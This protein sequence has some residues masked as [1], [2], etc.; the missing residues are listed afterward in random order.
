MNPI[1]KAAAI[2][3]R[4]GGQ[5][6]RGDVK[7]RTAEALRKA[8]YARWG[9]PR[10]RFWSYVKKGEPNECWPWKPTC[11]VRDGYGM[12]W[13]EKRNHQA[14]RL[15]YLFAKG[16]FDRSKDILHTCDNPP[17]CNPNH[18]FVGTDRDN[19]QDCLRKNRRVIAHGEMLPQS[20]L[21]PA[22]VKEIRETAKNGRRVNG[23]LARKFG[24]SKASI[25]AI[26]HRH[27]WKR[28]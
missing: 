3:G 21:S 1:S 19:Q 6:G 25:W 17:C 27:N 23:Q 11:R 14:H 7:A 8:A 10:E 5:A 16:E 13:F 28:V 15:A 4:K 18:L 9:N 12:F 26:V 24:V 22:Q 20:K 2:L